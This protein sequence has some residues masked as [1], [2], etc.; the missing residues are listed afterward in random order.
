MVYTAK[1]R[2]ADMTPGLHEA[3]AYLESL[4]AGDPEPI[5]DIPDGDVADDTLY[6][7]ADQEDV[8]PR[9]RHSPD[10]LLN[11]LESYAGIWVMA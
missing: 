7:L 2:T 5:A 10:E 6:A 11:A 3:L 1:T 8:K 9:P 4:R